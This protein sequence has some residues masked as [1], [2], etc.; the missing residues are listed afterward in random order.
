MVDL[1]NSHTQICEGMNRYVCVKDRSQGP[2]KPTEQPRER[3]IASELGK[4]P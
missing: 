2:S 1:K 4:K 3:A